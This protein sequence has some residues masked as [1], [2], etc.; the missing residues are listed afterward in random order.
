MYAWVFVLSKHGLKYNDTLKVMNTTNEKLLLLFQKIRLSR[1][2]LKSY[3]S[4][5]LS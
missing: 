5:N 1:S 2:W 4:Y 3:K